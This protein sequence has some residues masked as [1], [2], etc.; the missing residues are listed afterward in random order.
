L[1]ED[2]NETRKSLWAPPYHLFSKTISRPKFRP[3]SN[4]T[5]ISQHKGIIK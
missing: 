1:F 5:T 2:N 3:F 4:Y